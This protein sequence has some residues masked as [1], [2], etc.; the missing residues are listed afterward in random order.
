MTIKMFS[1]IN[2]MSGVACVAALLPSPAMADHSWNGY[3]WA[4]I[5]A[6]APLRAPVG[7]NVSSDWTVSL[8]LAVGEWRVSDVLDVPLAA[9]QTHPRKCDPV[10]GTM[11]ICSYSYGLRGWLGIAT[12]WTSG[13]HI[14]AATTKLNDSYFGAG[15]TYNTQ[16]WRDLVTCQEVGHDFGLAHQDENFY[17]QNLGTCMDYTDDPEGT[18]HAYNA[19]LSNV[20]PNMHDY[21][22]LD[23]IYDGHSEGTSGGGGGAGGGKG[24]GKGGG[25]KPYADVGS[26]ESPADWGQAT[27]YNADGKPDYFRKPLLNGRNM[28]THVFWVPGKARKE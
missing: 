13:D 23:I 12:V 15:S 7:N 8:Q 24:G 9:G 17:N 20:A 5:S 11:Q 27:H 26:G 4:G 6:D 22:E 10:D 16:A 25:G 18:L 1:R 3:H 19:G 28:I 2:L 14:L 21:D